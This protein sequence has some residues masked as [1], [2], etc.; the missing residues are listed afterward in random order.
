MIV[1]R[2]SGESHF[3]KCL[4]I[5]KIRPR[6]GGTIP[7][8]EE[9]F[10]KA[11][12]KYFTDSEDAY[13]FGC[14]ENDNLVSWM[15]LMLIENK[16]RGRFWSISTLYT[17][18]FTSYFSFNNEE[19]GLLIKTAFALAESKH[20]YEYYYSVSARISNVYERQ[21]QKNTFIPI[22]RYDYIELDT[23]PANTRPTV[24]L[25]WRLM[26]EEE[27]PDDIVIKKRILRQEYRN[28]YNT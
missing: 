6:V 3:L 21:I 9:P 23:V 20:Y 18:K 7:M 4:E 10:R 26:G 14:F 17:T 25:Y 15:G 19:I 8:A 11:F 27:K 12:T 2:L 28:E 16:A 5:S 22:G 24:D 1:K 13:A